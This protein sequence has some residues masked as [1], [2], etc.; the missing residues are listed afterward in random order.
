VP[1][2][3]EI[4]LGGALGI[5]GGEGGVAALS[6][7]VAAVIG[8]FR[9]VGHCEESLGD[10]QVFVDDALVNG[11][12]GDHGEACLAEGLSQRL[13]KGGLILVPERV[14][15]RFEILGHGD[16]LPDCGRSEK[17]FQL[18]PDAL[19]CPGCG[20]R[21][22]PVLWPGFPPQVNRAQPR[23]NA[24]PLGRGWC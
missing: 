20:F 4:C 18:K 9:D 13:G 8:H 2:F 22:S 15:D 6:A 1:E 14:G 11:V 21:V 3:L 5:L 7:A 16:G 12:A 24:L 19:Q 10:T 17:A 23:V